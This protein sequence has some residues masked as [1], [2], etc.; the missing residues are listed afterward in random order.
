SRR[1]TECR[2]SYSESPWKC[3]APL[4]FTTD[5]Y[6]TPLSQTRDEVFGLLIHNRCEVEERVRRGQHAILNPSKP[7]DKFFED[8]CERLDE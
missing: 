5:A 1:P 2:L 8:D 7:I 4:Y 3:I 6:G